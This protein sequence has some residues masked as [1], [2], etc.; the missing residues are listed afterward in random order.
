MIKTINAAQVRPL[1]VEWLWEGVLPRGMLSSVQGSVG[2]GKSFLTCKIVAEVSRGGKF[3]SELGLRSV[4]EGR[5]LMANSDDD[6][7]RTILGRLVANGA[8]LENIEFLDPNDRV[9]FTDK[10]LRELFAGLRPAL[11]VFDPLQNFY[12]NSVGMDKANLAHPIIMNIRNLAAEF[13]CAVLC[14]QHIS[15]MANNGGVAN[16]ADWALGSIG[17]NGIF[18]SVWTLGRLADGRRALLPSKTSLT[19]E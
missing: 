7:A 12:G 9:T 15:K 18:R 19:G 17:I 5:T 16:P 4:P 8:K 14:V 11:A 1:K 2:S 10:R 3:P 13:G 6:V